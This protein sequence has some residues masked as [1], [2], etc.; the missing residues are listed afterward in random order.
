MR[1]ALDILRNSSARSAEKNFC[2]VFIAYSS[3]FWRGSRISGVY[4]VWGMGIFGD[5]TEGIPP[6][7]QPT[8]ILDAGIKQNEINIKVQSKVKY[9]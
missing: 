5:C 7:L 6:P 1:Q 4:G 9:K 8:L 3:F 2:A